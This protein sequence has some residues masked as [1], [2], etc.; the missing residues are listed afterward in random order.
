MF[1]QLVFKTDE[2]SDVDIFQ[3]CLPVP[4]TGN[5]EVSLKNPNI[6]KNINLVPLFLVRNQKQYVVPRQV[7]EKINK[8]LKI[9]PTK[10]GEITDS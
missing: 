4:L 1:S 10:N 7:W 3:V 5:C 9:P 2:G 6:K 8:L